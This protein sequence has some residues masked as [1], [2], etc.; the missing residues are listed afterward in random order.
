LPTALPA[1]PLVGDIDI[2]A[3]MLDEMLAAHDLNYK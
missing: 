1:H 2:A 3:P